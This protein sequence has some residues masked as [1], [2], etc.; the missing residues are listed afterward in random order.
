MDC[1]LKYL[2]WITILILEG[3]ISRPSPNAEEGI[4]ISRRVDFASPDVRGP[5]D[6]DMTQPLLRDTIVDIELERE[7]SADVMVTDTG[8]HDDVSDGLT[9]PLDIDDSPPPLCSFETRCVRRLIEACEVETG[10]ISEV[11]LCTRE[12]RCVQGVCEMLPEIY[13]QACRT[14]QQRDACA[15]AELSCGGRA[16]IPFCLHQNVSGSELIMDGESCY[17]GRDCASGLCTRSG[18][19]SQGQVGDSCREDQDCSDQ[20]ACSSEQICQS[21]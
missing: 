4:Q 17:S 21:R 7:E 1:T 15:S 10:L 9:S 6:R 18:T 11:Q 14:P 3:C 12:E 20:H 5:T 19:C 8:N 2:V 13:G 16:A